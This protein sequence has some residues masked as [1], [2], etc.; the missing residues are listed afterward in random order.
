MDFTNKVALITG[1][2]SGL[3]EAAARMLAA[4]GAKVGILGRTKEELQEVADDVGDDKIMV[5]TADISDEKSVKAAVKQLTDRWGRLD[6]VAAVAGVNGTWAPI[7]DL[8]VEEFEKTI[9][10]NLTGTFITLKSAFPYLKKQGG[11]GVVVASVNGTR[12]FSNTGATAYA[13]SKAGQVA[14]TKMLA[15]EWAKHRV[16]LNVI[17]PGWIESEI[18]DNTK[19][20][21]LEAAKEPMEFPAGEVP[22]TD[23][24]PGKADQVAE[25]ISFLLSDASSHITGTEMWIDGAESLLRG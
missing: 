1:G 12:M 3:G 8:T 2:G 20:K 19:K 21:N 18:D 15:L 25:L 5:L 13:T 11:A 7:E 6:F 4:R 17:C 24:Q 10:I 23:G 9:G 14:M 22:L 16:R